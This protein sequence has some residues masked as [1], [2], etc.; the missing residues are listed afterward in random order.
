MCTQSLPTCTVGT[1]AHAGFDYAFDSLNPK[2]GGI[3]ELHHSVRMMLAPPPSGFARL[4]TVGRYYIPAL[5]FI[6]RVTTE[7]KNPL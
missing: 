7:S 4:M 5:Q 2:D 3:N 6:V 1:N